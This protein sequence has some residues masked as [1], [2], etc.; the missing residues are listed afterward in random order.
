NWS[1]WKHSPWV[2]GQDGAGQAPERQVRRPSRSRTAPTIHAIN[3]GVVNVSSSVTEYAKLYLTT[4][5]CSCSGLSVS[6]CRINSR[7]PCAY[8]EN[9]SSPGSVSANTRL[10]SDNVI[11]AITELWGAG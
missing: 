7:S 6:N 5:A 4:I 11:G 9:G 3:S 1:R 2:C 8:T 10:V